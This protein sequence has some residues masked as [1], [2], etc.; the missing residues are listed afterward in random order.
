MSLDGF[1]AGPDQD[2][3]HPLGV[4]G[5]GATIMGRNMFGPVRGPWAKQDWRGWWGP[6][7]PFHHP[8]FVLT[9]EARAPLEMDGRTTFHFACDGIESALEGAR[10]AAGAADICLSG[11]ASS[12]QQFLRAG[13]VDELHVAV[14]PVVLGRGERLFENLGTW[15]SRYRFVEFVPSESI[16]HYRF[17]RS[18]SRYERSPGQWWLRA[19]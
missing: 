17:E 5:I 13:L 7:P 14:V 9:H 1:M 2:A 16:A 15:T 4:D 18:T 19:T 8:V 3:Q 6:N 10:A 11:G 12:I